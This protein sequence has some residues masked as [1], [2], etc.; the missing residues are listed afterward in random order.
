M[1]KRVFACVCMCACVCVCVCVCVYVCVCVC[2]CLCACV[3]VCLFVCSDYGF[4]RSQ[5]LKADGSQCFA[6]F[7]HDPD[8]PPDT[9]HLGQSYE[10]ST[11]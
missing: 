6:D 5:A 9:C 3:C 7:W 4:E 2:V 8:A 1:F 11:G 10:S